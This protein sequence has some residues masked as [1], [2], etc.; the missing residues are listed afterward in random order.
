MM[1]Q[2][3]LPMAKWA[4][5]SHRLKEICKADGLEFKVVT[6]VL[7]TDWDTESD[8]FSMD[9]RDVTGHVE[10]PATKR[11]VLRVTARF[12]DHPCLTIA[13]IDN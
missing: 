3:R 8:T 7:G 1:N 5:N 13:N 11:Q 10:G 2:I 12:Y 6:Q 9:P 4:T